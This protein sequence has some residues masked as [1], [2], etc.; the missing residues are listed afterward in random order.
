MYAPPHF[1]MEDEA[2]ITS[3]IEA[4]PFATLVAAGPSGPVAAYAPLLIEWDDAGRPAALLGHLARANPFSDVVANGARVLA[5]FHGPDAYVSPSLYPTKHEHGRVVPTWNYLA[6]E[7]AGTITFTR[8]GAALRDLVT[9]LTDRMEA[10]RPAPWAVADAPAAYVDKLT[11]AIVGLRIAID[12]LEGKAKLSQN[13]SA[14]DRAGVRDGLSRSRD[15][16]DQQ[17]AAE[18]SAKTPK[19]A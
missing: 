4:R 11:N 8:D 18:M 14:A 10:E 2:A 19:E 6:V 3:L 5:I 7:A 16:L 17:V 15:P 1:S 9:Q 13:K 12:T